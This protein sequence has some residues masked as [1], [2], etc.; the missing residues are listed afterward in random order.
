MVVQDMLGDEGDV[1]EIGRV[2]L[3][4]PAQVQ[5]AGEEGGEVWAE[6]DN[7]ARPGEEQLVEAVDGISR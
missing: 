4:G 2:V 6:K 1:E 3:Q 5:T 7:Q